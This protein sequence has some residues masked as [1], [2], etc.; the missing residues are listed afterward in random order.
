MDV[1]LLPLASLVDVIRYNATATYREA[2]KY[3]GE[4]KDGFMLCMVLNEFLKY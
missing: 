2:E 1:A 4:W 3:V